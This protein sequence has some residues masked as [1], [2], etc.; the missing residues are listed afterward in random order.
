MPTARK[1]TAKPKTPPAHP[2]RTVHH[3][4]AAAEPKPEAQPEAVKPELKAEAGK[5]SVVKGRYI[6][7][8][9]RRKT[10]QAKIK[11]Y[12]DGTG[13]FLV[14]E[15]EMMNYFPTV[16]LQKIVTDPANLTG[17]L[18]KLNVVAVA[19]GGGVNAQA[20]AVALGI[21]RALVKSDPALKLVL[22]KEGLMTRDSRKKE[23]KKPGLKRA[24][25][26]PQWQKR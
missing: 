11:L 16:H 20:Q 19:R 2:R 15:R 18:K 8:I 3:P 21:S 22:K 6:S 24:R 26:A 4:A 1:K 23:R 25:R 9:G 12:V 5:P 10:A 7:A 14:N 13:E 17:L